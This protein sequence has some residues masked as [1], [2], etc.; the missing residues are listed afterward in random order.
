MYLD[1][2]TISEDVL[3]DGRKLYENGLNTPNI[4][5][6]IDSS[7]VWG[8][9]PV[10]PV[11]VTNAFSTDPTDRPFQDV[12]FDGLDDPGEQLKFSNYL[13]QL[14]Y[15]LEPVRRFI[16]KRLADPSADDYLNYR[17]TTYDSSQTDILGRYKNINNP[18]GNSPIAPPGATYVD[19]ST[20]YPDQEDLDH[21]NTMNELEQY[22]EYKVDLNPVSIGTVGQN[23]VTDSRTFVGTNN[24]SQTWYQF[25]IP[26][27]SYTQKV[28]NIPDFKSIRFIR[29][30][31]TGWT[32]SVVMRFAEFQL[33][34]DSWRNFNYELDTTGQY[35]PISP[36]SVTSAGCYSREYRT[37]QYASA[38]PLC[39]STRH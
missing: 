20:L 29:M 25:R 30:Y 13:N 33:I 14:A 8:R 28:G 15:N 18:Q 4:P 27:N 16:R 17:A 5:A 6:A 2:G 31:M 10:N 7:S 12:G 35:I 9:V 19:A 38:D 37:E 21:D 34:R 11:Q 22:F 23:F 3:K 1:L 32:D 39:S 24:V 36:N 26:I